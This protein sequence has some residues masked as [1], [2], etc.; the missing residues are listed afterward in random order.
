LLQRI[1]FHES[2]TY[3]KRGVPSLS[4]TLQTGAIM[5]NTR[6]AFAIPTLLAAST[7]TSAQA[8]TFGIGDY[9]GLY[10]GIEETT[11]TIQ[12]GSGT[13]QAYIVRIDLAAPGIGFATTAGKPGTT[14]NT[15]STPE[16]VT[17]TTS[18]F[19]QSSGAQIAINTNF[20]SCPCVTN[21]SN[22][23]YLLGL[24]I[25]NGKLVSSDQ[26]GYS[27]LLLTQNNQASL[28]TGGSVN[29]SGVYN[30]VSG[31]GF[32]LQNGVD[33]VK[34]SIP[35]DPLNPNPRSVVGLSQNGEYL[36]L[37]AIDG[38]QAGYSVGVTQSEE[39]ALMYALGAWNA[40]N[41]DGGGSTALVVQGTDGTPDVLN[42]PSGGA[43]RYDG[44]NL[45]VYAAPLQ[46][47]PLPPAVALFGSGLL[48]MLGFA[49]R[50]V[51]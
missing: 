3:V 41:F 16:V 46:P 5:K 18:Q 20:F 1:I 21:A 9:T 15:G 23:E 34:S 42:R 45:G 19:L 30:A 35:G 27:A 49:R 2:A 4:P 31:G 39:A 38:R 48:G 36:Y 43:E 40:V 8:A 47:V 14:P 33:V 26:S 24:E 44:A 32:V 7:F 37:M 28:V 51:V 11:A 17:Q 29:T 6:I 50:K 12:G 10:Q 22:T 13:S 25:S